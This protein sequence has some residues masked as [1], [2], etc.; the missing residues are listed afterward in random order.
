MD[1]DMFQDIRIRKLIKRQ[2]GKA[3]TV[4]ALLLCII[5]KDGYYMRWDEDMPFIISE[6]TGF[7]EAYICEAVNCCMALGLFDTALF[8][9]HKVLTSKGIQER[10]VMIMR[11]MKRIIRMED[12]NVL[13]SEV[14]PKT[15]EENG[16]TSEDLPKTSE[17]NGKTSEV[18]AIKENKSKLNK[19][20]KEKEKEKSAASAATPTINIEKRKKAFWE[21]LNP[22]IEKYGV[23]MVE[24]FFDYWSEYNRSRTK[25]RFEQQPTWETGKRMATWARNDHKYGKNSPAQ[26]STSSVNELWK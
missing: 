11:S 3:V 12:F 7:D 15:S 24:Q 17:E 20:E 10:Y 25:M 8:Q 19:K 26:S 14:L 6:Q 5:Y 23:D 18:E 9:S 13:Q 22:Y 16:K 21:S 4:Y 1:V 2:G